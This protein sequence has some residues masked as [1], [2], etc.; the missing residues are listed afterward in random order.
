M[1]TETMTAI[2]K[3]ADKFGIV[4]DWTSNNAMPY[5]QDLMH[6]IIIIEIATSIMW[7]IVGIALVASIRLWLK[8]NRHGKALLDEDSWSEMGSGYFWGSLVGMLACGLFGGITV[9]QQIYDFVI[10]YTLPETIVIRYLTNV[11]K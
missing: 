6:R 7:L 8:M 1:N 10:C 2:E 5:L 9:L 3:L 11:A 4:I